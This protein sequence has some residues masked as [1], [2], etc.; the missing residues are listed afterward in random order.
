MLND[1]HVCWIWL[2]T[3]WE[4][5]DKRIDNIH[6]GSW[7]ESSRD[8]RQSI[9]QLLKHVKSTRDYFESLNGVIKAQ[10]HFTLHSLCVCLFFIFVCARQVLSRKFTFVVNDTEMVESWRKPFQVRNNYEHCQK[11]SFCKNSVDD[12]EARRHTATTTT[13]NVVFLFHL[14]SADTHP[15]KYVS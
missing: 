8:F 9:N 3:V 12:L 13:T 1:S 2:P 14:L 6:Q 15:R 4:Q 5:C 11:V 7:L 10:I